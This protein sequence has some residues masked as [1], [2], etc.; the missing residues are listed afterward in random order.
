LPIQQATVLFDPSTGETRAMRSKEDAH[1]YRYFPD[2]DL[3]P[4]VIA[5]Q[6]IERVA[7]AMPELPGA[8]AARFQRDYA[9]PAA[10]ALAMTQ[11]LGMARFFEAATAACKQPKQVANWLMGEV[12]RRLNASETTI[13][14]SRIQ[15]EQLARLVSRVE[16]GVIHL[17]AAR[18]VFDEIW[19]APPDVGR[20]A[21][22]ASGGGSSATGVGAG[23]VDS[24]IEAKGLR[25]LNDLGALEAAADQAI[26]ANPKSVEGYRAGKEK[27]FNALVGQVMKATGGKANPV[28]VAELLKKRLG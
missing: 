5:P 13:E 6:W 1:D 7:A 3:P 26:A 20:A 21:A 9:L 8:M 17:S 27:A 23:L 16:E 2:P 14:H 24:I 19:S 25:Q 10:D 4:L 11:S 28:Q 12:S 15:P 18:Q 22:S